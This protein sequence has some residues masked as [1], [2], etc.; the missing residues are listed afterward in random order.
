MSQVT[1]DQ[2]LANILRRSEESTELVDPNGQV[3]GYFVPSA[4]SLREHYDRAWSDYDA[5]DMDAALA[6]GGGRPLS[7]ILLDLK[8]RS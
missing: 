2:P 6:E 8:T 1:I 7:E 4:V 5:S 3:I